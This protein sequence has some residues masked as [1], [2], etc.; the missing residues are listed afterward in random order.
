MFNSLS[1]Q[2]HLYPFNR[3]SHSSSFTA[4]F[5]M[6][7]AWSNPHYQQDH[8]CYLIVSLEGHAL[9]IATLHPV[10]PIYVRWFQSHSHRATANHRSARCRQRHP[11]LL[12]FIVRKAQ[13]RP[14]SSRANQRLPE[15][16]VSY[17]MHHIFRSLSSSDVIFP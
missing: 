10:D 3:S 1:N 15:P 6:A 7:S 13:I 4:G 14:S 11:E 12:L 8:V 2:S 17:R 5:R 16:M 9:L